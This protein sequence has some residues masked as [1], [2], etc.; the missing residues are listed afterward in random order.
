MSL[1]SSIGKVVKDVKRNIG[2]VVYDTINVSKI[3]L[4]NKDLMGKETKLTATTSSSKVNKVLETVANHPLTTA[5]VIAGGLNPKTVYSA[6]SSVVKKVASSVGTKLVTNPIPTTAAVLVGAPLIAGIVSNKPSLLV[7]LPKA[8]FQ[9]GKKLIDVIEKHPVEA[10]L[11]GAVTGGVLAYEVFKDKDISIG[12]DT[13]IPDSKNKN[14]LSDQLTEKQ[15]VSSP[16]SEVVPIT[17]STQVV[18]K[19][20]GSVSTKRKHKVIKK[21][22]SSNNVRVN[23]YNQTKS[24]Y[25]C[26]PFRKSYGRY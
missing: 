17:P 1:L 5:G 26:S 9:T 12:T 14:V 24:L 7:D 11:V 6:G 25:T 19:S 15:I 8:S 23:I 20:A 13:L 3:A 21:P 10:G 18:G 4:T 16:S 22:A 2:N